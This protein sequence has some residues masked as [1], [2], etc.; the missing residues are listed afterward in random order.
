MNAQQLESLSDALLDI[1]HQKVESVSI[2]DDA[3][4]IGPNGRDQIF[5]SGFSEDTRERKYTLFNYY[6]TV[7]CYIKYSDGV[8]LD[9]KS[10]IF[11]DTPMS[12]ITDAIPQ[13]KEFMNMH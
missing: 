2:P 4:Y 7:T 5:A 8:V 13:I 11:S 1:F 12:S 10:S 9:M 3:I 6:Y